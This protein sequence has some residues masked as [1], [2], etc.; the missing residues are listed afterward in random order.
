MVTQIWEEMQ[1]DKDILTI[2]NKIYSPENCVFV[3]A[4]LNLFLLDRGAG[5]G[6]YLIGVNWDK[7]VRKYRSQCRNPFTKKPEFLGYFDNELVAHLSWRERK[8]QHALTYAD[9]QTDERI[10]TAL[11][12]RYAD[13]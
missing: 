10:K 3:P 12:E 1:L 11:C 4:K 2:G 13:K 8:H 5:R 9:L 7:Q 6:E